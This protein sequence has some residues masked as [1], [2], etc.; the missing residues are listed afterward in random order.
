MEKIALLPGGF[1]PPHAGHYNM[2]KWLE[3][4]TDADTVVIKVGSKERDG[5]TREMSLKLWNLYR[6]TDPDSPKLAILASEKNSPVADVYD[7]IEEDAPE[8]SKIYLGAG[9]KDK[10]DSRYNNINKFADPKNI[11]FEIKLVPPQAGGVSGTE[12]RNFI[13]KGD[14]ESFQKYLPDHLTPKQ[15]DEAWSIVSSVKEDLYS[16]NDHFRD[17]AKTNDPNPKKPISPSYKY[18]RSGVYGRMYEKQAWPQGKA[19]PISEKIN[20][21]FKN[22]ETNKNQFVTLDNFEYHSKYKPDTTRM[23]VDWGEESDE[24]IRA[25]GGDVYYGEEKY[26]TPDASSKKID[27]SEKSD[28]AIRKIGGDVYY[29]SDINQKIKVKG[30]Q[31]MLVAPKGGW[32]GKVRQRMLV[33]PEEGWPAYEDDEFEGDIFE[34]K[35]I[36]TDSDI[37]KDRI[38]FIGGLID[39]NVSI[40]K[41]KIFY[42][43]TDKNN[44][45]EKSIRAKYI[46]GLPE[47]LDRAKKKKD[48]KKSKTSSLSPFTDFT[49]VRGGG[50]GSPTDITQQDRKLFK[51]ADKALGVTTEQQGGK[52]LR[53]YDFDDT[54]AVTKG[55]NIKIKHKDGSMDTLNPAEFAVYD[56]QE[57]DKFDFTEFDR[58]IKDAEPIQNIISMLRK[59]LE[60]TAKVTILT[61]RLIAY[62]V[63]RYL[64]S[65]DL[66]AY[67]VAVGSSDPQD[68]ANWI[69]NHIEK[70][71]K[72]IL[73]IDDSEKN[74]N[75]V[76]NLKD[77]YPDIKLDVQDPDSLSEMMYG[78]MNKA[79]KRKHKRTLKKI[80]K[81]LKKYNKKNRYF[82][83]PKK[84]RGS[85][86]RKL[87]KEQ[88]T[89]DTPFYDDYEDLGLGHYT[90]SAVSVGDHLLPVEVMRNFEDKVVGM[91]GREEMKAGML[92][93]YDEVSKKDFHMEGCLISLD[94]VFINKGIIDTIHNNCPPC[95]ESPCK[96]YSGLADNVLEL[97]GGYCKKH[98]I[99]VGD[100]IKL[101]LTEQKEYKPFKDKPIHR[102]VKAC[103][104]NV[105]DK[106]GNCPRDFFPYWLNCTIDGNT[107]KVGDTFIYPINNHKV[108]VHKVQM[109]FNAPAAIKDVES[110]NCGV[111]PI[112]EENVFT[113][114]WWKNTL[115]KMLLKEGGAAGHMAHPFNLSDVNSGSDLKDIFNKSA[116]SL[117]NDPG[118][119][120]IDGVNS[121]IR[122][123]DIDGTKQF[124]MDRGSKK[125][126]DVKGITKDDLLDRFGDGHGMVKI[127]GEVL[128]MFNKALPSIKN[129]LEKLGAYN[130]PN[131][132]FNMEYVSGKTNVQDYGSNFIAIH[133]L[134]KIETKE[135]Q[136][137]RKMLTKRVS[138]EVS[139]DKST[140]QSL[141]D[142]LTPIAKKQGFEVYGSVPTEMTKKPN[143][144]SALSTSYTIVSNEGEKTQTLDAWLNEL[145]NIPEEDFIFMNVDNSRKKV[146]AVSKQVYTTLL[147][148]ANIDELFENEEDKQKAIEGFTTYLAT[149]KLGDEVLKVLDSP[150]GSVE[151][152]EGVVIRDENIA[153]VPFKITGKFILGGMASDF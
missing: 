73:F 18:H 100:E 35:V 152:H 25:I 93:P 1:K 131:I 19:I 94:I 22:L 33:A 92:F 15:K 140:L 113:K 16:K 17:F 95:K 43:S 10:E 106:F 11:E 149:E 125:P 13:K 36:E 5:I 142:N 124:V 37:N 14:K 41:N 52:T 147:K 59:D 148:G 85:L 69:K 6:L 24:D 54:L 135:V 127:G 28:A 87:Y 48:N 99:N 51:Y 120:K 61:A 57:G 132:L 143:F 50:T 77:E 88:Y 84:W 121:S 47:D 21:K 115:N 108:K 9:E 112:N 139:Y 133:G 117:Q 118:S 130:D 97:P 78:M 111:G 129:D 56:A 123:V 146:G 68:K 82:K 150:M 38:I 44:P 138:S 91:G 20:L 30:K 34:G 105:L 12:M 144:S 141:L 74:R 104:C 55:A 75:A 65:L 71:Y 134:N 98:N 42:I 107:P 136:G 90:T 122:L 126:L 7:F 102:Y 66:D 76:L 31:R 63:R 81:G 119:V 3:A 53:V 80:K 86:T 101:N 29:G 8:G 96:R 62:P 67:V 145:N 137:K 64:K 128:D 70:G 116:E 72:D 60:T 2:A 109:G 49:D 153:K 26:K 32:P 27:W 4:N 46:S 89:S 79:E 39:G 103:N 114:E 110:T 23:D 151:N 45:Q 83:V 40:T 58:V